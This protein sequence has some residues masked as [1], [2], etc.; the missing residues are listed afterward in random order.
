MAN[1]AGRTP[2][3]PGRN[4]AEIAMVEGR[5][6]GCIFVRSPGHAELDLPLSVELQGRGK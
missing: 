2:T 6:R 4:F 1:F 5:V 3:F